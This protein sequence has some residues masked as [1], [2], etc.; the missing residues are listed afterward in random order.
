MTVRISLNSSQ[1]CFDLP[2]MIEEWS[3]FLTSE[4]GYDKADPALVSALVHHH[5][6]LFHEV[7]HE[8][9]MCWDDITGDFLVSQELFRMMELSGGFPYSREAL[10]LVW[11][12]CFDAVNEQFDQ[13]EEQVHRE[14]EHGLV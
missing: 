2:T 6:A 8:E 1:V 10:D 12:D 5:N 11:A 7:I 13:I 9:G 4:C 3:G 14:R